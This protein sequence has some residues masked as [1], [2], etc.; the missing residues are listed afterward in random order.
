MNLRIDGINQK[1]YQALMDGLSFATK[2]HP[3]PMTKNLVAEIIPLVQV[4]GKTQVVEASEM[5]DKIA[6][7]LEQK[8]YVK[9]AE[10][11]DV[12]SNTIDANNQEQ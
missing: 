3:S 11:I 12:I 5:L 6:N 4:Q 8:G 10:E 2:K 1:Q 7:V 9:E